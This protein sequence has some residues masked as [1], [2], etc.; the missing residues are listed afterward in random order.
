MEEGRFSGQHNRIV[1]VAT[2]LKH[3]NI[4]TIVYFPRQDSEYFEQKLKD[5]GIAYRLLK[6]RRPTLAPKA[7][8]LY[9]IYF[10]RDVLDL[11]KRLRRD[12]ID[13]AHCNGSWQIKAPLAARIAGVKVLWHLNDTK[14]PLIV[15][16][17]FNILSSVIADYLVLASQRVQSYY[18]NNNLLR[19]I[20]YMIIQAP[21]DTDR[22]DPDK[23]YEI[24]EFK[25]G[26]R[27]Q[28]VFISNITPVKG[29]EYFIEMAGMLSDRRGDVDFHIFGRRYKNQQKYIDKLEALGRQRGIENLYW[30]DFRPDVVN[31]LR[32]ADI[33]V[34]SSLYEASPTVVWEAM[35]MAKAIVTTDVGDVSV[36]I[37]N[38]KSGFVVPTR[39]PAEMALKVERLID[40][41]DLRRS[42]G[43]EARS[44]AISQLDVSICAERHYEAYR[45]AI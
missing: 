7:L 33:F 41:P 37:E 42:L 10:F 44:R 5:S 14:M 25:R 40:D 24:K 9:S 11:S 2:R 30:H 3:R 32:A 22:L 35:S 26:E 4:E 27:C 20:P 45:R 19:K 31:V 43:R 13:L 23:V 12:D 36:I 18:L 39:N 8:I 17:V 29:V 38:G 16:W 21:V 6:L 34:C 15:K 28:I 1:Q